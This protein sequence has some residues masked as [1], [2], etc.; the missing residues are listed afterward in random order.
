MK[1]LPVGLVIVLLC[2]LA[3]A[4]PYIPMTDGEVLE[5]LP[6]SVH[7]VARE[8]RDLR[9]RLQ[10]A[11][12]QVGY[13]T[14]LARR[15]LEIG[16]AEADPRYAGY[17]EAV[18]QPWWDVAEA[19]AEVRVLRAAVRQHRHEFSAALKDLDRVLAKNPHNGQAWLM[20]STILTVIGRYP[21][22]RKSC[23]ALLRLA[24]A[25]VVTACLGAV[26][27]LTGRARESYAALEGAIQS[28]PAADPATRL[29]ALT[30]LGE[31]A[32]RLGSVAQAERHFLEAMDL[33]RR[34]VYL[35]SAYADFLLDQGRYAE[36]ARLLRAET[37]VDGLLLRIALAEHALGLETAERV[38]NL[39]ARFEAGRVRGPFLH[40]GE[41]A[42]FTLVL[43]Q[44]PRR[45]VQLARANWSLQREPRDAR[46]L[47]EAARAA[48]DGRAAG[49]VLKML[50][51]AGTEDVVLRRLVARFSAVE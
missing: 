6:I 2:D 20:R 29:W 10:R 13:A 9:L 16:R 35:L 27:S 22:A 30:L 40:P 45:S 3:Q 24:D 23:L 51:R 11:P 36:V 7:R 14:E 15:Y 38:T 43:L 34:D 39:R 46:I 49:P 47:L 28:A 5:R 18:L 32:A 33:G 12:K 1:H 8:L 50:A 26:E 19:P 48:N 25:L 42:R 44:E 41:E 37:R 21:E 17:A 31:I 4:V